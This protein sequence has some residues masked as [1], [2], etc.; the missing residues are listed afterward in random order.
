MT[1]IIDTTRDV[2]MIGDITVV[3]VVV[4]TVTQTDVASLILGVE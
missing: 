1:V 3:I 2:V 4:M